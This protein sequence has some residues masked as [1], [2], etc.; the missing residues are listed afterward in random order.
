MYLYNYSTITE[1]WRGNV[2]D[3][4]LFCFQFRK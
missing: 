4:M 2:S 1:M 3:V